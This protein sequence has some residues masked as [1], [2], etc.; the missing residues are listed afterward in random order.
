[1]C[2]ALR[3]KLMDFSVPKHRLIVS[4]QASEKVVKIASEP[5]KFA[6]L[7]VSPEYPLMISSPAAYRTEIRSGYNKL[8]VGRANYS[9]RV[10]AGKLYDSAVYQLRK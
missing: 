8:L 5:S 7:M 3:A 4:G 6:G 1:M 2:R 9:R 10:I